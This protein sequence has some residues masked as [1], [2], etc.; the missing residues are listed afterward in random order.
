MMKRTPQR[1]QSTTQYILR[2]LPG[3]LP[4]QRKVL[5]A[6]EPE[7][8]WI[9]RRHTFFILCLFSAAVH[10]SGMGNRVSVKR[11][12]Q[13]VASPINPMLP[14]RIS[15]AW[16]FMWT[17]E[18]VCPSRVLKTPG[19]VQTNIEPTILLFLRDLPTTETTTSSKT[20]S[21]TRER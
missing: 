8:A 9:V 16:L 15:K 6:V 18:N 14:G 21:N 4:A 3:R 13:G 12:N 7:T 5:S 20:S 17:A 19:V 11:C 10:S 1:T 2:R